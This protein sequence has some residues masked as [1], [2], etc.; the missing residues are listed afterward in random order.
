[1]NEWIVEDNNGGERKGYS[2]SD[3]TFQAEFN[4]LLFYFDCVVAELE[5]HRF[6]THH[7]I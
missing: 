6:A 4:E 1:M 5:F 7:M 2:K 3:Q